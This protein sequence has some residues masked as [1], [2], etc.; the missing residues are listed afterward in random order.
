MS[1]EL[2]DSARSIMAI[3]HSKDMKNTFCH[4]DNIIRHKLAGNMMACREDL[5][6]A[7]PDD[8]YSPDI[9]DSSLNIKRLI[10]EYYREFDNRISSVYTAASNFIR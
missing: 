1:C 10:V 7:S 9:N 5:Y 6:L 3:D 8:V 2:A 4:I